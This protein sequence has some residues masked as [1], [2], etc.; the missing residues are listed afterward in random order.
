MKRNLLLMLIVVATVL[1][2]CIKKDMDDIRG[3][4]S[5]LE[6]WQNSVN[7]SISSL[8][9]IVSALEGKDYV[10]SVTPLADGSGYVIT[11]QK[12]GAVTIKNGEKGDTPVIGTRQDTDGKYYWTVNGEWLLDNGTKIATTGKEGLTPNIGSNGNWWIGTT[13]TGIK[14]QGDAIFA[15]DGVD[16]TNADYVVL[17]LADGITKIQLPRYK[18]FKIGTDESNN[19]IMITGKTTT[20]KLLL[21]EGF[22]EKDYT[23]IMAQVISDQGT[24]TAIL[25]RAA[26]TSWMVTIS[27]P[28]F[29]SDGTYNND[30]TITVTAPDDII[31][32][33]NAMLEVTLVGNDGN[34]IVATR[35]LKYIDAYVVGF[36]NE[37]PTIAFLWH[38]GT[39]LDLTDENS[40]SRASSVYVSD[41]VVYMVGYEH[42]SSLNAVAKLWKSENGVLKESISLTDGT[43][44][45]FASSVY[46]MGETVYVAGHEYNNSK[47]YVA[48]VWKLENGIVSNPISL[49]DGTSSANATSLYLSGE[50]VY[51]VGTETKDSENTIIKLWKIENGIVSSSISLTDGTFDTDVSSVFAVDGKVYVAGYERNSA[52]KYVAKLWKIENGAIKETTALTSGLT[53]ANAKSVYVWEGVA[54]VVGL[55]YRN[56]TYSTALLWKVENG[57]IIDEIS[58]TDGT[59]NGY[60]R[61]IYVSDGVAFIAGADGYFANQWQVSDRSVTATVLLKDISYAYGIFV[62]K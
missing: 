36:R 40:G 7:S 38:N 32:G 56:P 57:K 47:K 23:A 59:K 17:T 28:T 11:F 1:S 4:L 31:K 6:E 13:D 53:L 33:E 61:S 16:N 22:K 26:T 34:K 49:T 21:P 58:L 54:Y 12:I 14:A 30:A 29:D 44:Q 35:A 41:G 39:A 62:D 55:E 5:N 45:A 46:V 27:K 20:I 10:T 37:G 42:Y 8:Q 52:K 15:K 25:T 18:A 9:N 43:Q 3:R 2:S 19:A 50:V 51:V 60:P 24:G 48:K